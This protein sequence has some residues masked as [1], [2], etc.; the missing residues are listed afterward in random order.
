M[1]Y[2][3]FLLGAAELA[4][5]HY[6]LLSV[7]QVQNDTMSYLILSRA[8]NFSLAATG[9]LAYISECLESS[10]IYFSN[11]QEA[12]VNPLSHAKCR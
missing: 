4:L 12:S 9:D 2:I 8:T 3:S 11:S 1:S 6:R 5:E 7:K 10:H